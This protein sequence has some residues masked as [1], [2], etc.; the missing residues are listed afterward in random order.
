VGGLSPMGGA[1]EVVVCL[2]IEIVLQQ[3]WETGPNDV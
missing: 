3:Y 2:E 1:E